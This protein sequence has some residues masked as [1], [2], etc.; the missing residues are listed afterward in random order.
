[1]LNSPRSI[2]ALFIEQ[3]N[4]FPKKT[5][6]LQKKFGKYN[7]ITWQAALDNFYSIGCFLLKSGI[8]PG[9][10][11][12]IL[13]ESRFEW[14]I[15]D[16]AIQSVGAITVP[17]YPSSMP[18]DI[19]AIARDCQPSAFFISSRDQALKL[20][21][22]LNIGSC[23]R[24]IVRMEE[25]S[26]ADQAIETNWNAII[27]ES[28]R[29]REEFGH[30]LE[31]KIKSIEPG[32]P[33][34]IIYTSGTTGEPKGVILSHKN[35]L[36]NARSSLKSI[37]ISSS[38]LYLSFLPL[39][40]IFER[41]AGLYLM[42]MT[43]AA[44]AYAEKM[45]TVPQDMLEVHPTIM[46]GVPRFFEKLYARV[47]DSLK[48]SSSLKKAIIGWSLRTGSKAAGLSIKKNKIPI[49]LSIKMFLAKQLTFNKL[50]RKLGGRVRFFVSGGAALSKNIGEFFYSAGLTILEG[51][52]LTET[53][54]VIAVN[55]LDEIKFGSVG[56]PIEGI[57]VKIAKDGEILTRGPHVMTGYYNKPNDT[58]S[59]IDT[60]GWFYTGDIGHFDEE[61]FLVITDRKKDLIKTAGG[62]FVAPQKIESIFLTDKYISQAL[63]FGERQR[64][65]VAL[66]VP[67]KNILVEW[68]KSNSIQ[69]N[70]YNELVLSEKVHI[71]FWNKIRLLQ[72]SLPT[73]E[74]VKG[75]GLIEHEFSQ[76]T[77]ELTPTLKTKRS[78]IAKKYQEMLE[79]LFKNPSV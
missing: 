73:F 61:G 9:E 8:K 16:I 5:L 12:C 13:S 63:V 22:I 76:E 40:H 43:G 60:E 62:K 32:F 19:E 71:F 78:T 4:R 39:S 51:Y 45:D 66:I 2:P 41:M 24:F 67:N 65:C 58:K 77:G 29:L 25:N 27:K 17:I 15:A 33:A 34:T 68:A 37:P 57:E 23:V 1:M 75:I 42:I 49:I 50:R 14:A 20:S 38:D 69:F 28:K 54:P 6:F 56:K 48:Q 26:S 31:E 7:Q 44:I 35:F 21:N 18:Q 52:G 36:S 30:Q 64:Y 59:A 70:S 46:L 74:Q 3:A 55:K 11:V 47:Q 10:R 79:N 72:E 53:S